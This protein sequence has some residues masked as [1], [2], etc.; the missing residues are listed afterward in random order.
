M[1]EAGA[2]S[3][4]DW[5]LTPFLPWNLSSP[6][7]GGEPD[8]G[9]SETCHAHARGVGIFVALY[10]AGINL[11]WVPS[12]QLLASCT[13]SLVRS[14]AMSPGVA[15]GVALRDTGAELAD[16]EMAADKL[17][18]APMEVPFV[19]RYSDVPETLGPPPRDF[20][21]PDERRLQIAR[22]RIVTG[23]YSIGVDG[24]MLAKVDAAGVAKFPTL[25]GGPVG[26]GY[27][28]LQAGQV[29]SPEPDGAGHAQLIVF[30]KTLLPDGSLVMRT[31]G[32]GVKVRGAL[33]S[34]G[35]FCGNGIGLVSDAWMMSLWDA[36]P[37]VCRVT[38]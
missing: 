33:T 15:S 11:G 30:R 25:I 32:Q 2:S 10:A 20:P 21:E 12:F 4:P 7:L 16:G 36:W 13:Y 31:D 26:P 24:D 5:D 14:A 6:L 9:A 22:S 34:W 3:I 23:P 35:P 29:A 18:I 8:Q 17:G 28:A 37:M 38:T 19:G 1:L 27:Q